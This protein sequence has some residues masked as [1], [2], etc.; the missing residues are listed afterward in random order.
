[1]E[2]RNT[3]LAALALLLYTLNSVGV[4]LKVSAFLCVW[5]FTGGQHWIYIFRNTAARDYR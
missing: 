4:V 3:A 2:H 1:M 5:Y